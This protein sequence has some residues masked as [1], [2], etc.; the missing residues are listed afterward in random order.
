MS[1]RELGPWTPTT[2]SRRSARKGTTECFARPPY[3]VGLFVII[4]ETVARCAT[5]ERSR[6]V[7]KGSRLPVEGDR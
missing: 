7:C 4:I 1:V 5:L 3:G 2:T 6:N